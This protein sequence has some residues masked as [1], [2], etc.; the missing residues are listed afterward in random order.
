MGM[1]LDERR[2][3]GI[4]WGRPVDGSQPWISV[5]SDGYFDLGALLRGEVT[6]ST[7]T[8]GHAVVQLHFTDDVLR[9]LAH[10]PS[11]GPTDATVSI[12]SGLISESDLQLHG[13]LRAHIELGDYAKP[14]TVEPVERVSSA[15]RG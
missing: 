7:G 2:I 6:S 11:V 15:H 3:D 10:I 8:D 4:A 5:P 13:G 12:E 1:Q 9:A 14:L